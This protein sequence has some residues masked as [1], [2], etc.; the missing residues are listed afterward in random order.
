MVS[1]NPLGKGVFIL[2]SSYCMHVV[3][4]AY[5]IHPVNSLDLFKTHF[6]SADLYPLPTQHICAS[7]HKCLF[8]LIQQSLFFSMSVFHLFISYFFHPFV[9]VGTRSSLSCLSHSWS[10]SLPSLPA[11]GKWHVVRVL[12]WTGTHLGAMALPGPNSLAPVVTWTS[13][14]RLQRQHLPCSTPSFSIRKMD[15]PS[16]SDSLIGQLHSRDRL[17]NVNRFKNIYIIIWNI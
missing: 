2:L 3:A 13:N 5:L 6:L 9:S 16:S 14:H 12:V 17:S 11:V 8:F 4:H 1:S 10:F 7:L 15:K